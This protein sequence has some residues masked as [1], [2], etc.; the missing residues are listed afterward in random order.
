MRWK[1]HFFFCL[2]AQSFFF[3]YFFFCIESVLSVNNSFGV[4]KK[5]I[6]A[7]VFSIFLAFSPPESLLFAQFC[8]KLE[9]L[10]F[11][12]YPTFFGGKGQ[13]R[14]RLFPRS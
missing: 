4:K 14:R 9:V 3:F 6:C 13:T 10:K 2:R 8:S 7:L 12:F 1:V 11:Y 5:K